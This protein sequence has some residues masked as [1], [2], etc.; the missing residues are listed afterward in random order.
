[1]GVGFSSIH[2]ILLLL[3]LLLLPYEGCYEFE[4][5]DNVMLYLLLLC[6]FH[7]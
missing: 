7:V 6:A 2:N 4:A 5:Q 3:L 1:M